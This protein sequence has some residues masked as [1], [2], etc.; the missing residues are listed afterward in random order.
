MILNDIVY[1]DWCFNGFWLE[2]SKNDN[3]ILIPLIRQVNNLSINISID[4]FCEWNNVLFD[5]LIKTLE[6]DTI[7][8]NNL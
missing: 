5:E 4:K 2:Y 6:N 1:S 8:S 7:K 3:T